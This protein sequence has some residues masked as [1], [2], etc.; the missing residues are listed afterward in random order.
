M[1]TLADVYR[2]APNATMVEVS[3]SFCDPPWRKTCTL[4]GPVTEPEVE[5]VRA[6]LL[7]QQGMEWTVQVRAD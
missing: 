5:A 1:T 2:L 3:D 7:M 4:I 6:A